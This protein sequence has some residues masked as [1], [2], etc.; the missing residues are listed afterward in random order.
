V[1][2][3]PRGPRHE[4]DTNHQ[5]D[6]ERDPSRAAGPRAE[7]EPGDEAGARGNHDQRRHPTG[8]ER[9]PTSTSRTQLDEH[10]QQR[11]RLVGAEPENS[12]RADQWPHR[13][14]TVALAGRV[15][16]GA[17]TRHR[18]TRRQQPCGS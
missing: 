6:H 5:L 16:L 7:T 13:L 12:Q 1:K 4:A 17:C 15:G 10:D 9:G 14:D 18:R 2:P 8:N 3:V 11:R